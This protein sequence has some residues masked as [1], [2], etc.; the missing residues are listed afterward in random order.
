MYGYDKD[1]AIEIMN[2]IKNNTNIYNLSHDIAIISH[3]LKEMERAGLIESTGKQYRTL[4]NGVIKA[5][6][7]IT[8]L[9]EAFYSKN[10]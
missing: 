6:W 7:V 1:I 4:E 10:C 9:G 3:N 8:P 2:A 5:T